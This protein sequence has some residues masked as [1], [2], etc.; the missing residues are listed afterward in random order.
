MSAVNN[1]LDKYRAAC[2]LNSDSA[3]ADRLKIKRQ[4]VHQWRKGISW[5]SDDH[6]IT[7][8]TAAGEKAERW[9]AEISADRT[10]SPEARKAW[11][12][13]VQA[14]AGIALA[15]GLT[16]APSTG[17]GAEILAHNQGHPVYYVKLRLDHAGLH[18]SL[19]S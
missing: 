1:L 14:A 12:R 10:S 6:V 9:L 11:R 13:L 19:P 8:T 5:P 7:M 17:K 15:A 2:S 4:A 18:L 3:V 16:A